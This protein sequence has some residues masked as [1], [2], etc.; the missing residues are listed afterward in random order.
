MD[1]HKSSAG[2]GQ[3][4]RVKDGKVTEVS[5]PSSERTGSTRSAGLCAAFEKVVLQDSDMDD[6]VSVVSAISSKSAKRRARRKKAKVAVE[7]QPSGA[8]SKAGGPAASQ[9]G[10]IRKWL[11]AGG[12]SELLVRRPDPGEEDTG[13]ELRGEGGPPG[14]RSRSLQRHPGQPQEGPTN[15]PT[16]DGEGGEDSGPCAGGR[17]TPGP[18]ATSPGRDGAVALDDPAPGSWVTVKPR[19]PRGAAG[20][21]GAA[22]GAGALGG[23]VGP[24]GE[25]RSRHHRVA[26]APCPGTAALPAPGPRMP[27]SPAL[28]ARGAVGRAMAVVRAAGPQGEGCSRRRGAAGAPC[29][30]T[31]A[32]SGLPVIGLGG[33]GR[34]SSSVSPPVLTSPETQ[35]VVASVSHQGAKR[36]FAAV[37]TPGRE[38]QRLEG[39]P[40]KKAPRYSEALRRE[41]MVQVVHRTDPERPMEH[42]DANEV[43]KMLAEASVALALRKEQAREEAGPEAEPSETMIPSVDRILYNERKEVRIMPHDQDT[44]AWVQSVINSRSSRFVTISYRDVPKLE[45]YMVFVPKHVSMDKDGSTLETW[46][47]QFQVNLRGHYGL[48]K[49]GAFRKLRVYEEKDKGGTPS[50]HT[51]LFAMP[52][53]ESLKIKKRGRIG[54][55]KEI[56]VYSGDCKCE[57]RPKGLMPVP[58]SEWAASGRMEVEE[59]ES[60]DEEEV[61]GACAG[62]SGSPYSA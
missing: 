37:V 21:T 24:Q 61:G 25:G 13:R 38:E 6:E 18:A 49:Q 26:G 42:S 22:R 28:A 53:E 52:P 33:A 48:K 56:I 50:G 15:I 3:D 30:G 59:E 55:N 4:T 51:I 34:D 9:S 11:E 60:S 54:P 58:L 8:K 17:T 31:A 10:S 40:R 62:P 45:K 39:P 29:P 43:R 35:T 41:L 5:S 2:K 16:G 57:L 27:T 14:R 20:L 47:T 44:H 1:K 19:K 46:W 23:V 36:T 7:Q 12:P 32:P